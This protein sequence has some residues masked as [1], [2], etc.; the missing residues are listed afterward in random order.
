MYIYKTQDYVKLEENENKNNSAFDWV[1]RG[2]WNSCWIISHRLNCFE[3]PQAVK[4]NFIV[5]AKHTVY[6]IYDCISVGF[7]FLVIY[8]CLAWYKFIFL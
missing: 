3:C 7:T 1:A 2:K 8:N 5:Y 6:N 4:V